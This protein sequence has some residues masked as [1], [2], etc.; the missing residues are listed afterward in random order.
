MKPFIGIDIGGTKCAVT[1]ARV[2]R[3]IRFIGKKRFDSRAWEGPEEML[4]RICASADE[5]LAENG[6][7][8]GGI[9]A[10]G[11]SCGGPLDSSKGVVLCPPHLP[12]WVNTSPSTRLEYGALS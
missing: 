4:E 3:G 8:C 6:L 7:S 10:V 2:D 9:Q 1:L 11:V 12:G 5:L